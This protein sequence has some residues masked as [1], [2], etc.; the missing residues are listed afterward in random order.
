VPVPVEVAELTRAGHAVLDWLA[1]LE[2][3]PWWE[4]LRAR[5]Y[6]ARGTQEHA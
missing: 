5:P 3:T 4:S 1:T 2:G 6:R